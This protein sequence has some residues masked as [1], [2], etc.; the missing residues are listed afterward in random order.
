MTLRMFLRPARSL[1]AYG[2][3]VVGALVFSSCGDDARRPAADTAAGTTAGETRGDANG[4]VASVAFNASQIQHGGVRWAPAA[5][6]EIAGML[7]MPAQL[8]PDED[9]TARL[10]AP[11]EGR[12]MAVHVSPGQRVTRGQPL[13]TLQSQA[14]SAA[15]ADYDKARAELASRQAAATYARTARERADRLLAI[16]AG[17]RQEAERAAADDELARAGL[18]QA[19][20]EV[21]RASAVL[22]TLGAASASG[23]LILRSPIAGIVLTRSAVPGTVAA[24][25]TP[26]VTISDQSRLW[27]EIAATDRIAPLLRSGTHVRF[28]VPAFPAD[29]FEARVQS[30]GGALDADTRTVPVRASVGNAGGRLRAAMFAKAWLEGGDRRRA[31]IVPDS[32]V[33]LLDRRPV[34]FVVR[35]DANGG[36]RFERR[37]VEVTAASGGRMYVLSGLA[38]G[39]MVVTAGAFAVK[40]EFARSKMAE[41]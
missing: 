22:T 3:L 2:A 6:S 13:V 10:G 40:S 8:V 9:R 20:A 41:G 31:V 21:A 30:I 25:G 7:E 27:L 24:P 38:P 1:P 18:A 17:S 11:A 32:A 37:D 39:E 23:M 16:K 36:A 5:A 34:V 26:L 14:A 35:L 19:R 4:A 15:A 28:V 12:V 29:T 33:Q